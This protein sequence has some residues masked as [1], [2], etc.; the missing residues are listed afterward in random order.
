[1]KLSCSARVSCAKKNE[2][3]KRKSFSCVTHPCVYQHCTLN[4]EK[5]KD[6]ENLRHHACVDKDDTGP[7][8]HALIAALQQDVA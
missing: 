3:K 1:M 2:K 7:V 5:K 6:K 8:A 4:P